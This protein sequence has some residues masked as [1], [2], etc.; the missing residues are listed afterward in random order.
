MSNI[1]GL[2]INFAANKSGVT[3]HFNG[4]PFG[5]NTATEILSVFNSYKKTEDPEHC[6]INAISGSDIKNDYANTLKEG[7]EVLNYSA[8]TVLEDAVAAQ[9]GLIYAD[10]NE[11]KTDSALKFADEYIKALDKGFL[12]TPWFK[13]GKLD[14]Q[15]LH[16]GTKSTE[17]GATDEA[18]ENF[19]ASGDGELDRN[20]I[21][22]SILKA[23]QDNNGIVTAE[24]AQALDSSLNSKEPEKKGFLQSIKD[25]FS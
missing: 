18:F 11:D 16:V 25:F 9:G 12:G 10:A 21:A 22:D 14:T 13:N 19:D 4:T 17:Q 3:R 6:D 8:A 1:A 15:E 24:E 20:E 23:D 7:Q 5:K 2:P